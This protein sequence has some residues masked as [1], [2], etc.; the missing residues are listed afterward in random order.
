MSCGTL[1]ASDSIRQRAVLSSAWRQNGRLRGHTV[2][3]H[4][5]KTAL[6]TLFSQGC[7]SNVTR[8]FSA[9]FSRNFIS[10]QVEIVLDRALRAAPSP[11][12][13]EAGGWTME[14]GPCQW[15]AYG[16]VALVVASRKL[17]PRAGR[18]CGRGGLVWST[19]PPHRAARQV[20]VGV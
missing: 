10:F 5:R 14:A 17:T 4:V 3:T 2:M 15:Q 16:N 1:L 11:M 8:P 19:R 9:R 6:F 20:I 18:V 12:R 7:L 13:V